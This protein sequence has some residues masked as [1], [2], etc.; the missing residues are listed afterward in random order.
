V[1]KVQSTDASLQVDRA[2]DELTWLRPESEDAF[3]REPASR[4]PIV[5]RDP[6]SIEELP[7]APSSASLFLCALGTFGAWHLSR[8]AMRLNLSSAP[9]WFHTGGPGQVGHAVSIDWEYSAVAVSPVDAPVGDRVFFTSFGP[10]PEVRVESQW[11]EA[12][13]APRGP[14][15]LS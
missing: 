8:S 4:D 10:D 6:A 5:E 15:M 2:A 12:V 13:T 7:P 3:G 14:P 11:S 9:E 1:G